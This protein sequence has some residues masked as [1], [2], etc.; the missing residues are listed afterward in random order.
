[1][2]FYFVFNP[3]AGQGPKG[4]LFLENY[5]KIK[6]LNKYDINIYETIGVGDSTRF[7]AETCTKYPNE[8]ICFFSCGGDGTM[9]EVI[10][11]VANYS[12]AVLGIV[13]TG[14]CNDFL[15]AFPEYDFMDLEAQLNGTFIPCDLLRVDEFY[16]LNVTNIGFDARVNYDQIRLRPKFT[17][18]V[19]KAYNNAIIKNLVRPLGDKVKITI[20]DKE[21]FNGKSLLMAFGNA[22]F[23]GGGYNCTPKAS[24][25]DGL[26]DCIVIKKVS[27]LTFAGLIGKYK[28][29]LIY[30]NPKYKKIIRCKK[31]TKVE[32]EAPKTLTICIDGET[33]HR[34]KVTIEVLKH[35]IR[36]VLPKK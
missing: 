1:M 28:K 17:N 31:A 14:S 27:I 4:K 2:K 32:I 7:V 23:Y 30:D 35:K 18:N 5:N 24:V 19:K 9:N 6:A 3:A 33:I 8:E 16:S 13:P 29:G 36:F 20:D 15:K 26:V 21:V 10:T 22:T 25:N 11:G 34:N 12:N